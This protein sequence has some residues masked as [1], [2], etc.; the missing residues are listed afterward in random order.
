M[1]LITFATIG[2]T[3]WLYIAIPKG[4]FPREDTGYMLAITEGQSDISFDAMVERQR[5]VAEIVRGRSGG[6][7]TSIRRSASAAPTPRSTRAACWW[8]SSPSTSAAT[9]RRD[10]ADAPRDQPGHRHG[11]VL[12]R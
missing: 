7:S 3:V 11:R 5:K 6:R 9:R 10:C 2:G 8:R 12:S 1:L 4:F